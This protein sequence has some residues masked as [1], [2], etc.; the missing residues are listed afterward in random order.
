MLRC[1]GTLYMPYFVSFNCYAY[2]NISWIRINNNR[3]N[4][5]FCTAWIVSEILGFEGFK[6]AHLTWIWWHDWQ[7][8]RSSTRSNAPLKCVGAQLQ[9]SLWYKNYPVLLW[10]ISIRQHSSIW[11]RRIGTLKFWVQKARWWYW[12]RALFT[13]D[14][15]AIADLIWFLCHLIWSFLSVGL[16][17]HV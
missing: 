1:E 15:T 11:Y 12:E 10:T 7:I 3:H 16:S 2:W 9:I 14:I 5:G 17:P 8:F 4:L 6:T 13:F